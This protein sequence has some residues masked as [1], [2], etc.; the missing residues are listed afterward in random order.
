MDIIVCVPLY[1]CVH[2]KFL[3]TYILVNLVIYTEIK[4]GTKKSH[5]VMRET[6]SQGHN[7]CPFMGFL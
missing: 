7:V 6:V 1:V 4:T 2:C 3:Y 5:S